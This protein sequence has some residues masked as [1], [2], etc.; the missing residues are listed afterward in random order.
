MVPLITLN[1]IILGEFNI[2][3]NKNESRDATTFYKF[4]KNNILLQHIYFPTHIHGN[5]LDLIITR[6]ES[7]L[8][9]HYNCSTILSDHYVITF[10]I[11]VTKPKVPTK[12]IQYRNI[13]KIDINTISQD[14]SL[15][16][17]TN[18]NHHNIIDILNSSLKTVIDQHAHLKIKTIIERLN[19]KCYTTELDNHKIVLRRSE[20]IYRKL[21]T[22]ENLISFVNIRREHNVLIKTTKSNFNLNRIIEAKH[23]QKILFKIS[24][25]LLGRNQKR[26]L[27]NL[28]DHTYAYQLA[29]YFETKVSTI[30]IGEEGGSR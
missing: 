4:L 30:I 1:T 29:R 21:K 7:T 28:D 16:M 11:N 26:I 23:D 8:T 18:C 19:N 25:E 3:V 10:S 24:N 6:E 9:N 27:P 22:D 20:R 5:I 13:S 17:F 14:L 2:H 12:T 15:N